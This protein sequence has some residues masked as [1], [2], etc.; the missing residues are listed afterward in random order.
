MTVKIGINGLGRIGRMVVRSILENKNKNIEI[1]HIN[2]RTNSEN[3][4]QLLKYDSIHGKFNTDISFNEKNLFI[5]KKKIYFS[6]ETELNKIDWKKNDVDIVLECTGK[7]NSKEK[8]FQ[9]IKNGAKKIIVSAPC[10][11]ADK[12]IVFGVN[13]KSVSKKD[14]VISSASCTTNCLAPVAYVLN[15]KFKIEKLL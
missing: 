4:S 11:N 6:Q 12:T 1:R 10:K 13:H 8:S 2:N 14:L 5:N 9:H 3:S 15:K 7:N